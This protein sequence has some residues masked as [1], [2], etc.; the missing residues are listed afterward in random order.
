MQEPIECN[1]QKKH[2]SHKQW[3]MGTET[4]KRRRTSQLAGAGGREEWQPTQAPEQI[5]NAPT[6]R[7]GASDA[8]LP[9]AAQ[10]SEPLGAPIPSVQATLAGC[11]GETPS[12][13]V[14]VMAA[15]QRP[16]PLPPPLPPWRLHPQA[17]TVTQ[18]GPRGPWGLQHCAK[19]SSTAPARGAPG[20]PVRGRGQMYGS[21]SYLRSWDLNEPG[22]RLESDPASPQYVRILQALV[23]FELTAVQ[24]QDSCAICYEPLQGQL[25]R[26]L[27]C[28]HIFHAGCIARWLRVRLC[29]PLDKWDVE[30]VL[31]S[32]TTLQQEAKGAEVEV[33]SCS[34]P[35]SSPLYQPSRS[36]SPDF[37]ACR[38]AASTGQGPL[39]L[40]E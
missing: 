2:V 6:D 39:M 25:V 20:R 13:A 12:G 3:H 29:C 10:A 34:S 4:G 18:P 32:E 14:P 1:Q 38:E 5:L 17:S 21:Q 19:A 7:D 16:C 28:M 26:Q 40:V 11:F 35:D 8:A 37:Q 23:P 30:S 9:V 33:C 22:Q 36:P 31:H 27:P 15:L 24:E